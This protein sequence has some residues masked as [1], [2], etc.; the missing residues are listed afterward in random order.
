MPDRFARL[1]LPA[2]ISALDAWRARPDPEERPALEAALTRLVERTGFRGASLTV[3]APPLVRVEV[4]AGSL[5]TEGGR[6]P[7]GTTTELPLLT[8]A[9]ATPVGTLRVHGTGSLPDG[10][11][12]LASAIATAVEVIRDRERARRA[13][14]H[15]AALDEAVQG[16]AAVLD[17]DRVLQR[18]VDRVRGLA[19]ADY[20]ALG[21]V[22]DGGQIERFITSG[23]SPA[24]RERI[25]HPPEGRGLLGLI[26]REG[27]ALRIDDVATDPR[28]YGF[29]PNHPEMRSFLGVPVP[30]LGHTVGNLYLT[31]GTTGGPFGEAD[32]ELVERFA[33]HAGI[34][35]ENARLHDRVQR[36]TIVEERERIGRDL[37]DQIIQR[38]YAISLA[39]DDV[40]ELMESDAELARERVDD[41]IESLTA[42]IQ[43]IRTFVFGL[44][45]VQLDERGLVA[46]LEQLAGEMNRNLGLEVSIRAEP[47]IE[48]PMELVA[49]L[50]SVARE[51]LTNVAR[52]ADARGAELD[53]SDDGSWFRLEVV[54]DGR[55]FDAAAAAPAGHHGLNNM[56]Q[57][58]A[59][60]GGMLEVGSQQGRGTRI[61]LTLPHRPKRTGDGQMTESE[62]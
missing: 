39:L 45:P 46:A 50:L 49:E 22:S 57:R 5:A 3:D 48:P 4:H 2:F 43:E 25:G 44:R 55:G 33:L 47:G 16:I 20:A 8:E 61:I 24:D 23:I 30:S 18:I 9:N 41:A 19:H 51:A 17:L 62:P 58:A 34:A 56:R 40:P 32:Q 36:L 37:H 6:L 59:R 35:I 28:R 14:A 27:R 54:D 31:R 29:P 21:I 52:H 15:L 11:P 60:L 13:E 38:L 42:A 12:E 1:P 26:I 10:P 7:D 53:L